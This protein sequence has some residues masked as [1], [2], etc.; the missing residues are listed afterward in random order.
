MSSVPHSRRLLVRQLWHLALADILGFLPLLVFDT[1]DVFANASGKIHQDAEWCL[2]VHSQDFGIIVSSLVESHMSL[3]TF[4]VVF[5]WTR[6][7]HVLT[8]MLIFVWP[9]GALM[10]ALDARLGLGP[11][12][13]FLLRPATYENCPWRDLS[14]SPYVHNLGN[15]VIFSSVL[16]CFCAYLACTLA[17][18]TASLAARR[19]VGSLFLLSCLGNIVSYGCLAIKVF[20]GKHSDLQQHL[21]T[22]LFFLNGFVN[23]CVY[24]IL[25]PR[26]RRMAAQRRVDDMGMSLPAEARSDVALAANDLSVASSVQQSSWPVRFG[27]KEQ[28]AIPRDCE[29][30]RNAAEQETTEIEKTGKRHNRQRIAHPKSKEPEDGLLMFYENF[31]HESNWRATASFSGFPPS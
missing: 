4:F 17:M 3:A 31:S 29:D 20:A 18:R 16:C 23:L 7:L 30:A 27:D 15:A 21:E 10:F 9:L 12:F 28:I 5:G 24:L 25:Q 13:L 22:L 19:R 14:E 8:R 1:I 6:A 2:L 11:D 26:R